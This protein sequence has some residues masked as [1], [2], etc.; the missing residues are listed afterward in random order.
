V[1][2]DREHAN[3]GTHYQGPTVVGAF[4]KGRSATG[5]LDLAGNVW[6]WCEDFAED[7]PRRIVKGGAFH[8]PAEAMRA[9]ARRRVLFTHRSEHVGF[10]IL[11]EQTR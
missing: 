11:E 6:E 3:F 10:R 2:P 5:C 8:Y 9:D 4:P 7:S 1:E